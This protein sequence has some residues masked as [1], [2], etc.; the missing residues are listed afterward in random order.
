MPRSGQGVGGQ[1]ERDGAEHPDHDAR[2]ERADTV[3][4]TVGVDTEAMYLGN[5]HH[6]SERSGLSST[7]TPGS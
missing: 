5:G 7:A 2:S 3:G 4:D 6:T 1:Q